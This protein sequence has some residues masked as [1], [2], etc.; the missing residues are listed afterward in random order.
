MK[1]RFLLRIINRLRYYSIYEN[2]RFELEIQSYS[3]QISVLI[4]FKMKIFW[5][6]FN[7]K[8]KSYLILFFL[9]VSRYHP[10]LSLLII[11]KKNSFLYSKSIKLRGFPTL[12]F[13]KCNA[14]WTQ[15]SHRCHLSNYVYE[16]RTHLT[17]V[18][19]LLFKNRH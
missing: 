17:Y 12:I 11:Q 4:Q 15:H 14:N 3:E 2:L 9:K 13:A 8:F 1:K 7:L 10:F 16:I 19:K 5:Q 6:N 18:P